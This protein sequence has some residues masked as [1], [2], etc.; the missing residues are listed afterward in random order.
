MRSLEEARRSW[1]EVRRCTSL[2]QLK[3]AVR[4]DGSSSLA[5]EGGRS[6]CW[7][8][9]LLFES[10][11]LSVWQETLASSRSAYNSLRAHFSRHL[12][13]PD[14]VE[15]SYDPLAEETDVSTSLY[16]QRPSRR[17]MAKT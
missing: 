16:R 2:P 1:Q 4:L 15:A 12:D 13:N 17:R 7:K 11:E 3:E 8:A 5:T 6:A 14:S 10:L 9:F